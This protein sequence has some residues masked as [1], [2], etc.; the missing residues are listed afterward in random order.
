MSPLMSLLFYLL[1]EF[2]LLMYSTRFRGYC[3]Y[4]CIICFEFVTT[5]HYVAP[6]KRNSSIDAPFSLNFATNNIH[7]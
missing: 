6:H 4:F 7:K 1:D 5:V 2:E 3:S